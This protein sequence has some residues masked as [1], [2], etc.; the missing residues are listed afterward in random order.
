[1]FNELPAELKECQSEDIFKS[2]LKMYCK[3]LFILNW[4]PFPILLYKQCTYNTLYVLR[5]YNKINK[6]AK[7]Y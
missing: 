3:T 5:L 1:M 4:Y 7:R 2:L 6:I